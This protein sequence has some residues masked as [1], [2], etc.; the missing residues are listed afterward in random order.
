MLNEEKF[1][2]NLLT[3]EVQVKTNMWYLDKGASNHMIGDQAKFQELDE[4]LIE[5]V[6]FGE[7]SIVPIQGKVSILFQCKNGDQNLLMKVY[8]IQ[9]LKSKIIILCHMTEE[10]NKVELVGLFLNIRQK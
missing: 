3:K 5:N 10:D 4:K 2:V 6:K 9:N 7:K 8:Y 1:M